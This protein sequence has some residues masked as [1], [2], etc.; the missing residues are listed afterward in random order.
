MTTTE[1]MSG[2]GGV[3]EQTLAV[4][5]M[6]CANCA[7]HVESA[8][9]ET[10]GVVAATVDLVAERVEVRYADGEVTLADLGRAVAD[11]G[12]ELLIPDDAGATGREG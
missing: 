5:G 2:L 3:V 8:L 4:S 12:Y 10:P 7:K 6:S 1:N 9:R 11:S